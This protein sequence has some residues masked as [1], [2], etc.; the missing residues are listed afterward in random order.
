MFELRKRMQRL[1][2]QDDAYWRQRAKTHWYKDGDRNTQKFHASATTRKKV[3]RIL[4]L[5]DDNGS[6]ITN[7]QGL[8]EVAR[9][10]FVDIFQKQGGDVS[11]V[12]DV[13]N[14]SISALANE[15]LTAPFPEAKFRVAMF[16]M[17]PDKCSGQDGYSPGF[18]YQHLWNLCSDGIF[19][20]CCAWLETGVFPPDLNITNIVLIPKGSTQVSMKDWHHIALCNV[21]YK[22]ISKVLENRLKDVLPQCISDNQTAFVSGRSILDNA[23]VAIEV[24]HF[25]K[26]KKR[27]EDR[28][29][30]LKL[31]ISKAY[32]RIDWD[33]LCAVMV[34]MGFQSRWIQWMSMCVE[35]VD[36]YVLVN[37]EQ[38]GPIIPG[39]GLRQGDP[40]SPY[41]FIIF[42]E[43]L[44]SLI[45]DAEACGALT[46]TKIFRRAPPVSH[47]LFVDDCFLFFRAEEGEATVMKNILSLYE[48]A[49]RQAIS[50]PKSE[51]YCSRNVPDPLKQTITNILGV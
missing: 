26:T 23:M 21:L 16:A 39:C 50:L 44:S 9:Q 1:L 38:V 10:Y 48:T 47:L 11:S 41:L 46:G 42:A 6:K 28:Y 2:S 13:I 19:K 24:L 22:I 29:V 49:S 12:I 17:E 37:G 34:K 31:D 45:R 5:D 3:N 4:S 8:R 33:Y 35:S 25:M 51:I 14:P 32:D 40:L 20:E 30:A 7:E 15:K 43:G 36:Y 18:F 27:G